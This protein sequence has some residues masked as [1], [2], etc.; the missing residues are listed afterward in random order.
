MHHWI[1]ID[2]SAKSYNWWLFVWEF[3][4]VPLY[5]ESL[6]DSHSAWFPWAEQTGDRLK[7][8]GHHS[9]R[10]WVCRKSAGLKKL[11]FR[12]AHAPSGT[13]NANAH[14]GRQFRVLCFP[15]SFWM[16]LPALWYLRYLF[17]R[18]TH[19]DSLH[20]RVWIITFV[21]LLVYIYNC[22]IFA[23]PCMCVCVVWVPEMQCVWKEGRAEQNNDAN[24]TNGQ[25]YDL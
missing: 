8:L 19:V 21:H 2:V 15:V 5:C 13:G 20:S 25:T 22:I 18:S 17:L 12:S 7:K 23:Y 24:M 1:S 4:I 14:L 6:Q 11:S 3:G 10:P 9:L 16:G